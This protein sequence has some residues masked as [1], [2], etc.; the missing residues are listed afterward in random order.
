MT[1]N[2]LDKSGQVRENAQKNEL[3]V[4]A[5]VQHQRIQTI[6]ANGDCLLPQVKASLRYCLQELQ[7]FCSW[8]RSECS[9]AGS[10]GERHQDL[11]FKC[12]WDGKGYRP[13]STCEESSRLI[14]FYALVCQ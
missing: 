5:Q 9:W 10:D 3:N 8:A 2:S 1:K 13:L 4:K 7:V 12:A 11:N 6:F 14:A